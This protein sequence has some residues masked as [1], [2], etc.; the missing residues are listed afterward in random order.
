MLAV[1]LEIG[2][3]DVIRVGHVVVNGRSRPPMGANAVF[4]RP[5]NC[6]VNRHICYVDTLR[7]QFPRH[8][9]CK[10]GLGMASHCKC[11]TDGKPLSAAVAFV[12]MIVPL[13]PFAFGLFSRMSRAAR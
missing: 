4:L 6:G 11:T 8:A 10:S 1:Q 5:A 12:K 3:G 7:H 13:A 9:L 2:F